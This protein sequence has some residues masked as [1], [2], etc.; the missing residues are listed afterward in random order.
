M[1]KELECTSSK[2][3]ED[4]RV[5]NTLRVMREMRG[6]RPDDFAST[7]GISRPYLANIEAGRKHLTEVLLARAAKALDVPQIAIRRPAIDATEV[8]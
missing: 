7:I 8:A 2:S 3:M 6:Y 4:V 5:G 1:A